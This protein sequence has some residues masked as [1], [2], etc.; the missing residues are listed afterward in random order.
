MIDDADLI[1]RLREIQGQAGLFASAAAD[2]IEAL[3]RERDDLIHDLERIKNSE[4]HFLNR[5]E[6]L[7]EALL[8]CSGSADFNEGGI[9]HKGWLKLCAPLL[10]GA[11][12][13]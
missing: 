4:T 8:W 1:A 9:A 6:R 2:R 13:D 7:E 11:D 10:K 12:H 3:V 5:A